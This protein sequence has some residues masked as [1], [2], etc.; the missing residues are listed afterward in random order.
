MT[1]APSRSHMNEREAPARSLSALRIFFGVVYLT[2]GLAKATGLGT[3]ALGPW[4]SFLI[5][6]DRAREILREDAATSFGAYHDLVTQLVL[7]HYTAFGVL[8]T[9]V[10]VL[11]G[12]GLITGLWGRFAA[13]GGALHTVNLQI[14]A[15]GHGEW[16]F[17]Y[18]VVMVPLLYLAV[19][20]S[21]H[22]RVLDRLH[23][24]L[25]PTSPQRTAAQ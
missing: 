1:T 10:E 14:A 13:L 6:D 5:N 22:L 9:V 11:V 24:L 18:L 16:A 23:G 2:N 3:F 7:P 15:L 25:R 17:E 19:V 20:P 8:I 4:R 12:V 21:R